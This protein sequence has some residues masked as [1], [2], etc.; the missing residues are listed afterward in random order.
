[1]ISIIIPVYNAE[2][3]LRDCIKAVLSQ[4]YD[5][6]ELILVDDGS[7]DESPQ[8]CD[9]FSQ[10]DSR[11]IVIHKQNGGV[12][13]TRNRGLELAKGE[14][15]TFIDADD[16]INPN[17]LETLYENAC[18][19]GADIVICGRDAIGTDSCKITKVEDCVFSSD[20]SK[21]FTDKK[22]WF[23]ISTPWGKLFSADLIRNNNLRF[24][25][26]ISYAEDRKFVCEALIYA[27]IIS[28]TSETVYSYFERTNSLSRK[29]WNFEKSIRELESFKEVSKKIGDKF[30]I[31]TNNLEYFIIRESDHYSRIL[32]SA[33]AIKQ[34]DVRRIKLEIVDWNRFANIQQKLNG[35]TAFSV[36][37]LKYKFYRLFNHLYR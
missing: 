2:S 10:R 14:Y 11:I 31:N 13:S 20:K 30:N 15:I 9:E 35:K 34:Y 29:I 27:D 25:E 12:S 4:T 28:F 22:Y 37:L 8:I 7:T 26:T 19:T 3:F 36:K 17:Y 33:I 32:A 1:M 6:W 18:K 24:D 23:H 21:I 16:S 5:D